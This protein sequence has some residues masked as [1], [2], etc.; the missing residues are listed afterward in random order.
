MKRFQVNVNLPQVNAANDDGTANESF[1]IGTDRSKPVCT[2]LLR[3]VP[4]VKIENVH[5]VDT[6]AYRC[7][8]GIYV[9]LTQWFKISIMKNAIYNQDIEDCWSE[10]N[11]TLL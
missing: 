5:S 7:S 8:G 4:F 1:R 3:T 9:C 11:R 10:F 2:L 6:R